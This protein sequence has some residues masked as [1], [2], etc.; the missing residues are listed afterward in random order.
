MA[1]AWRLRFFKAM[2]LEIGKSLLEEDRVGVATH[3]LKRAEAE[4]VDLI[5]PTDTV[6][7]AEMAEGI[8]AQVCHEIKFQ[9]I[10]KGLIS[11]LRRGNDFP[12]WF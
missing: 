7:A 8:P 6:V 12:M 10:W 4:D 2:G 3:L 9:Q 1:V 11:G 5:L